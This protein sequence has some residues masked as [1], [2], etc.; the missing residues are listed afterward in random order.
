VNRASGRVERVIAAA[1][2]RSRGDHNAV[3][4]SSWDVAYDPYRPDGW[5][6]KWRPIQVQRRNTARAMR[7]F[8]RNHPEFALTDAQERKPLYL[9]ERDN[10]LSAAWAQLI[11]ERRQF[12]SVSEAEQYLQRRADEVPNQEAH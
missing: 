12:V 5:A 8:A 1:V 10:L 6:L 3:L 2:E 4:V 11:A 7:A 9:F